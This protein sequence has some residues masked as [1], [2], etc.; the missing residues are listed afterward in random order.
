[1][2]IFQEESDLMES[3]IDHSYHWTIRYLVG[4]HDL[5]GS[6]SRKFVVGSQENVH[7]W[8]VFVRGCFILYK[9]HTNNLKT[10][11]PIFK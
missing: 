11:L 10:K 1:M 6:Y 5:E 3:I 9:L 8:K 2:R 7:Y 4:F